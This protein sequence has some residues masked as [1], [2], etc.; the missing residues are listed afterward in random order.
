MKGAAPNPKPP[1]SKAAAALLLFALAF[2]LAGFVLELGI[3][4]NF[5]FLF[6]AEYQ[7]AGKW[8]F[9]LLLPIIGVGFRN[10][11]MARQLRQ[12][13]PTWWVRRL[14]VYPLSVALVAGMVVLAPLG[15]IAA[16]A[17]ATGSPTGPT[18]G[19]LVS[20]D[21]YRTSSKGCGQRGQLSVRGHTAQVCL[22]GLAVLPMKAGTPIMVEGELSSMGLLV[23]ELHPP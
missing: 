1:V 16:F 23:T 21:E 22:E 7:A 2:V 8:A 13:Y 12:N 3:G 5:V 11:H 19:R 18:T 9:A 20:V 14:L 10:R 4:S 17:W 15:W 6:S